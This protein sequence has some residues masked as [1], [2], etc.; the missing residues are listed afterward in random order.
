MVWECS[1]SRERGA[2]VSNPIP[3]TNR[4][5]V[6]YGMRS[7]RKKEITKIKLGLEGENMTRKHIAVIMWINLSPGGIFF[8]FFFFLRTSNKSLV[9]CRAINSF[10]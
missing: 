1:P 10:L 7:K 9:I 5:E 3:Y 8:L 6:F 2:R 4:T